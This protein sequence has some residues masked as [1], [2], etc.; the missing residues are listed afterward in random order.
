MIKNVINKTVEAV[1][2][3][4]CPLASMAGIFSFGDGEGG[5]GGYY[6]DSFRIVITVF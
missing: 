1:R 3:S 6:Y 2:E 4:D 5:T